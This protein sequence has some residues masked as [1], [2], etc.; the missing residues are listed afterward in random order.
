M[1]NEIQKKYQLGKTQFLHLSNEEF[2]SIY[3]SNYEFH[4]TT[5]EVNIAEPLSTTLPESVDWRALGAVTTPKLQGACGAC[6][7]FTSMG[8]LEGKHKIVN[9]TLYEFSVQQAIDCSYGSGFNN[10]CAGGSPYFVWEYTYRHKY[11]CTSDEYPYIDD[12]GTCDDSKCK[13]KNIQA[14]SGLVQDNEESLKSI[15]SEQPVAIS[16]QADNLQH[17]KGGIYDGPCYGKIN[18]AVLIVG[19]GTE[20]GTDYWIIKNSWGTK[21]GMNGFMY[22]IRND[23]SRYGHCSVA[24]EG[25]IPL[26]YI[27][28]LLL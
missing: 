22:L 11:L 19:Y 26:A 10:G 27:Y 5:K 13:I 4:K 14:S 25:L 6:Y 15:V 21:W 8:A 18:H 1:T 2:R 17:Y 23:G 24:V 16:I 20:N 12:L 7:A 28:I 9:G 3:L